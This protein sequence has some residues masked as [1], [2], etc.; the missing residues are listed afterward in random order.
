MATIARALDRD[1]EEGINEVRRCYEQMAQRR[2]GASWRNGDLKLKHPKLVAT[3][4][5]AYIRSLTKRAMASRLAISKHLRAM[6]PELV[7]YAV[8]SHDLEIAIER[9][10][11]AEANEEARRA[12]DL[13][14]ETVSTMHRLFDEHGIGRWHWQAM[15][16]SQAERIAAILRESADKTS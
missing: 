6:F 14:L 10:R 16:A 7:T 2:S 15:D 8:V 4:L 5:P 1:I 9:Q 3:Q 13:P 11:E 12:S